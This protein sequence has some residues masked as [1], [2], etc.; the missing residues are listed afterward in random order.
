MHIFV[1]LVPLSFFLVILGIMMRRETVS[2]RRDE[3]AI[4]PLLRSRSNGKRHAAT[5]K[6]TRL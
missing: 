1:W 5:W 6:A 2:T 3:S 4:S